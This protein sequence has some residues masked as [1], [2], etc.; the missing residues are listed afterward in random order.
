MTKPK[1]AG[2]D[3]SNEQTYVMLTPESFRKKNEEACHARLMKCIE[4]DKLEPTLENG[5]FEDNKEEFYKLRN[6]LGRRRNFSY[7]FTRPYTGDY[8]REL[9]KK[10]KD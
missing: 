8:A 4:A 6:A 7:Y 10:P 9:S 2:N 5:Y 1:D 3:N